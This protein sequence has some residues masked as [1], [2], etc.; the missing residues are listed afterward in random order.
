MNTNK[1][2]PRVGIGVFIF[3][4]N[5]QILM[6]KRENA[7]GEGT[8]SIPGGHL[9]FGESF[10]DCACREIWEE[11]GLRINSPRVLGVTNDIFENENRHYVSVFLC[12]Q[13]PTNQSPIIKEPHKM[14]ELDWFTLSALPKN[15]FLPFKNLIKTMGVDGILSVYRQSKRATHSF[16]N[17]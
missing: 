9:E 1:I 14:S 16:T 2:I 12:A 13:S 6:G 3:N 10:E 11:V 7:H 17:G 5:D 8:W 15:I 4:Q